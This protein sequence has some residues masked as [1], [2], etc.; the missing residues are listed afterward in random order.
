[1]GL[2]D[3]IR[4]KLNAMSEKSANKEEFRKQLLAAV[5]DGALS[6]D[7]IHSLQDSYTSLGLVDEDIKQARVQAYALMLNRVASDGIVTGGEAIELSKLEALL[8]I[9]LQDI[10]R[11]RARLGRLRL[12][13][14]IQLGNPPIISV[15]SMGMQKAEVAHWQEP[16]WLLEERVVSKTYVGGS[17]GVSFRLMKGVTYRV[18]QSRG[19]VVTDSAVVKVSAGSLVIT[20]RRIVF[21]GNTKSFSIALDKVLDVAMFSDGLRISGSTGKPRTLQLASPENADI[22]GAVLSSVMNRSR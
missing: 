22:V 16:A 10:A 15:P 4:S 18:G 2:L 1:M 5:D 12:I 8:K 7:E 14:E 11:D 19:R 9:P 6:V 20:N 3:S 21:G 13:S 17:S